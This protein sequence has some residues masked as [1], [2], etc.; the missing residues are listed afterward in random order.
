M[1]PILASDGTGGAV[2]TW[3]DPRAGTN[4]IYAQRVTAAGTTA[5]TANGIVVSNAAGDQSAP[6]II[7]DG[8]GG[9]MIAWQDARSGSYDIYA[10]RLNSAG[11]PL[12]TA[13]GLQVT[14]IGSS[15]YPLM[16]SDGAGGAL[17]A[18]LFDPSGMGDVGIHHVSA[19]GTLVWSYHR[20]ISSAAGAASNVGLV[21]DGSG[22][23]IVSWLDNRSFPPRVYAQRMTYR[24]VQWADNG[25]PV[26]VPYLAYSGADPAI[27]SDG[28]GGA[29]IT[30]R[31]GW[32][33]YAQKLGPAGTV[34]WASPVDFATAGFSDN[35][36]WPRSVSDGSGGVITTWMDLRNGN[37]DIYAQRVD[38]YGNVG[39]PEPEI[40]NV[41]DVLNDQGGKVRVSW[42]ASDLDAG[43]SYGVSEYRL[44]RQAPVASFA[45]SSPQAVARRTVTPDAEEAIAAGALWAAAG[46]SWEYVGSQPASAL[47]SYSMV[48]TTTSD[49]IPG[50]N[51]RSVFMVEARGGSAAS[52]PRWFS[53]P[54]SGYSV[55]NLPPSAPSALAGQYAAGTTMLHWARNVEADFANYRVYRGSSAGFVPGPGNLV[56]SPPDTGWADAA[57]QPSYYK[58]S[59][60][61]SHGNESAFALLTP[62]IVDVPSPNLPTSLALAL[63]TPSPARISSSIAFDLPLAGAIALTIHDASGRAVRT[64]HRGAHEAGRFRLA[65]DLRDDEGRVV[66][67]GVYFVRLADE[68]RSLTRRVITLR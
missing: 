31:D 19:S 32:G 16:V 60:I 34:G 29:I 6:H 56:A 7:S 50:S 54:D 63:P 59:A 15:Q 52:A 1:N 9:A 58:L 62:A 38:A 5:W 49:S 51:P 46:Y 3:V 64:L 17:I 4:D 28:A 42:S 43:P 36:G 53:Q 68:R 2:L 40:A 39:S 21:S 48:T 22:G 25:I 10:Q 61:D 66:P 37:H 13:N 33:L 41:R 65:W 57:G 27:V 47:P 14:V 8:A 67:S 44:W 30:W 26:Y 18:F 20:V 35:E 11:T 23:A 24:G 45:G 55:D 12:W